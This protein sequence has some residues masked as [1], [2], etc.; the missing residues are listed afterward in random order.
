LKVKLLR[1][2]YYWGQVAALGVNELQPFLG[3]TQVSTQSVP[4]T[5]E[6]PL[7]CG[8]GC[9]WVEVGILRMEGSGE[10]S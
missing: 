2:L 8:D 3:R 6:F 5:V 4:W 9:V 7:M 10:S 1:E